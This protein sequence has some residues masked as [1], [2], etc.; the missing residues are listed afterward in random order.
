MP[1]RSL[2]YSSLVEALLDVLLDK[3]ET[4]SDWLRRPLSPAQLRYAA[5]DVV[6]LLPMHQQ[7]SRELAALGRAAWLEEE[8][9]HQ[10]RVRAVDK[11][12]ET[13]YLKVRGRDALS[14]AERTVLRALS[15]WRESEAMAR[16]MPPTAPF[17]RRGVD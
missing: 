13:A 17:D 9:E 7:L 10:R 15:Q 2:G 6:Y 8:L 5:L 11:Q 3:G 14:T 4:R 12:P 1:A 16:D